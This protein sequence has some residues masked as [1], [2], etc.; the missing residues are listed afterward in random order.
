MTQRPEP[1]CGFDHPAHATRA[2][3][4]ATR[5]IWIGPADRPLAGWW[6]APSQP[7]CDGV[8]IAPPLG[9]EYWSTHRSLRTLAEQ[10]A[11]A[12]YNVLRFDWDGTGDSAGDARDPRRVAHWRTSLAHAVAAMRNAGIGRIAVIGVR[13]G[14]AMALLDAAALGAAEVVACAPVAC[15]KRFVR[16][17]KLLG[18]ADPERPGGVIYSGLSIDTDTAGELAEINLEKRAAPAV[19]RTF[20]VTRSVAT[21]GKLIARL[22]A[23]GRSLAVHE[24]PQIQTML[25][26]AAGDA[27]V[28]EG[29]IE[30]IVAWLGEA[31]LVERAGSVP[32][33]AAT[34][35]PWQESGVRALFTQISGLAAVCTHPRDHDPDTVVVFLNS[36]GEPHV[37]PGRAWVEYARALAL[38]GYACIRA[39]FRGWGES[40]DDGRAPGR[41]YDP[42]CVADAARIVAALRR[43]YRRVALA[44]LCAGAWIA[45]KA[46]QEIRVDGVFALSPQLYWQPG[47]PIIIRIPDSIA[48]RTP[49]RERHRRFGRWGVWSLLDILGIRPPASRWLIALRKR[50]TPVM[51][52]FAEGDDGL[53]FLRD[54]CGR[55]LAREIRAGYLKVEEV[56]G[57]DHQMYRLWRRPAVVEQMTR[58]LAAL[59]TPDRIVRT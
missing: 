24:C 16:E 57:I 14:A 4:F 43:R 36:G 37:G 40:P 21:S 17:I 39:D 58:F 5:G 35:M 56:P 23:D 47:S 59:S 1:V 50:R 32:A 51:L 53:T 45:L 55:R 30:P 31:R 11:V 28:P 34:G 44:G 6:T 38:R 27:E 18:I 41:P 22:N 3:G 2:S 19:A 7:S 46:A 13:L 49:M 33:R 8:V 42:H 25:D 15:G 10:L 29:F 26:V 52:S 20:I 54:R 9:Y 48:W 12:G